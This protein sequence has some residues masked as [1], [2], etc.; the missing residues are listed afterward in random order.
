M[1]KC[2]IMHLGRR[3]P[4]NVYRMDGKTLNE[5]AE[6]KDLGVLID[7]EL[8]FGKHIKGIVGKANK[9]LGMIR[10]SFACLNKRMFLNLYL[11][12]VRPLLEYCVQVWSPYKRKYINLV[13]GVQR[14]ATKLVPELRNSPYEERL[15]RLKLTTL[16]ER[17]VRGD[18][19]ETY[20]IITGKEQVD[21][22]KF[23]K[24]IPDRRDRHTKKIY[25][26]ITFIT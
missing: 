24:I 11:A 20:K 5:T 25:R 12:L 7:N 13:E 10:I 19:I 16:E 14:R 18:M 1:D 23:F 21:H 22:E 4:K 15:R 3:N 2:K 8:D 9:I 6:E 26:K 17:R